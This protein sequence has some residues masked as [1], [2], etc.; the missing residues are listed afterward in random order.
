MMAM[1]PADNWDSLD[2]VCVWGVYEETKNEIKI[3]VR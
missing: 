2:L 3:R 1:W